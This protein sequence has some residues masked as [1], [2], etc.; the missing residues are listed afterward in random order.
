MQ[1]LVC[2]GVRN[3]VSLVRGDRLNFFARVRVRS[4]PTNTNADRQ[5]IVMAKKIYQ[6]TVKVA[7]QKEGWL[8]TNDPL[9]LTAGKRDVFVDLAA[10]R[11][12]MAQRQAEKIAIEIKS[13]NSP[14]PV[15]DLEQALGQYIL[16]ANLLS[17]SEPDRL[18]Y[19]AIREETYT[20]FFQEEMAQIVLTDNR[21][22]LIVFNAQKE[23]IVQWKH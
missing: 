3:P 4:L 21:I 14:S 8:I 20:D 2:S 15:K 18:L 13:F 19:L 12:L 22:K 1:P 6:N 17:R 7:L 16:Y 23:E 11:I 9:T 10:E 5:I